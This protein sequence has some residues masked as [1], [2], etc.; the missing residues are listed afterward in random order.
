MLEKDITNKILRYLR[1][2]DECFCF[3]EHGGS[4]GS[5]GI[6]DIIIC[7]KGRFIALEVKTEKGKTTA[8]Q[9]FNINKINKSGGTAVVV[10]SL[11][12]AKNVISKTE[13][14]L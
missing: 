7:Y 13:E 5:C 6:P 9:D 4:Y 14:S 12:D 10:R 8:L 11:E 1:G 3:K 2:L